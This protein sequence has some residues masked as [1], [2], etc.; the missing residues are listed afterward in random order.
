MLIKEYLARFIQNVNKFK[1]CVKFLNKVVNNLNQI[2]KK[3]K[4]CVRR[5]N[6]HNFK[7]KKFQSSGRTLILIFKYKTPYIRFFQKDKAFRD[8]V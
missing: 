1:F 2:L 8:Q 6:A 7:Y 3:T 4:D 5:Q